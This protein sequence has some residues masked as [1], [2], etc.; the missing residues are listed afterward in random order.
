MQVLVYAN[1]AM[2]VVELDQVSDITSKAVTAPEPTTG[3]GWSID[4][5]LPVVMRCWVCNWLRM[6][7]QP[8]SKSSPGILQSTK[9]LFTGF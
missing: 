3:D 8:A 9:S 1:S 5:Q 7:S 6:F 4:R 2:S